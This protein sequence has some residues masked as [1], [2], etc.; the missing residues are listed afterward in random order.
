M[1]VAGFQIPLSI[2]QRKDKIDELIKRN[3]SL[4]PFHVLSYFSSLSESTL[5][6]VENALDQQEFSTLA[7]MVQSHALRELIRSRIK[8]VVR[9]KSGGGGYVLYSPNKGKKKPSKS[10]GNFPTKLAAKKAELAR[11]PPKDPGKL[12]RLRKEIDRALKDPKKQAEKERAA[13]KQKGT[14]KTGPAVKSESILRSALRQLIK[15]SLFSEERTGSE[16]D[17]NLS[18]I[19]SQALSSDKKFQS[20]QKNIAKKT[21]GVLKDALA[22]IQKAVRGKVKLKDHGVKHS[23]EKGKTYLSF[24]AHLGD[25]T[26][27]PI[28]IYCEKGVPKIEVSEQ[29]KSSLTKSDPD[30]AKSFRAELITVQERVLDKMEDLSKAIASRDKY[31]TGAEEDIDDIISELSPLQ[32][33]LLKSLLVKKYRKVSGGERQ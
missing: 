17:E 11:F 14:V 7:D 12:K 31:L 20:L 24:S 3:P 23:S 13:R 25:I 29:A 10:V 32:I 26:V 27:E 21:E 6:G 5:P 2:K 1:S 19:P 22:S 28:Y 16:W 9:K 8:E 4:H 30:L 33:S 18:R 15:E